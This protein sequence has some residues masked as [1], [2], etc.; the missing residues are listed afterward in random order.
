MVTPALQD[1]VPPRRM[2]TTALHAS[3]HLVPL[4]NSESNTD[5]CIPDSVD[6]SIDAAMSDVDDVAQ[7]W[8]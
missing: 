5:C 2:T 6:T 1:A 8:Q 3:V 4:T 7:E